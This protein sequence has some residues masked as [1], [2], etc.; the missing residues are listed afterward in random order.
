MKKIWLGLLLIANGALA[1]TDDSILI[2]KISDE[3]LVRGKA[4]ENLRVL[5]KTVGAR[6]S[7][8]QQMYQAEEWGV[9]ALKQAGATK[10]YL[11]ECMVPY[12]IRGGKDI[13]W[14][15]YKDAAGKPVKESLDVLA[16]GNSLGSGKN[17]VK[18]SVILINNFDELEKR[19]DELKGKIVFYNYP[20]NPSYVQTF[21]AYG[22]S[23]IYRRTGPS[24]A[25]K[26]GAVAV[27]IRSMSGSTDNN[28]HTGAT[29]YDTTLPKI[30]CAA[31]GLKDADK[32]SKLLESGKQIEL[33]YQS[34]ARFSPIQKGIM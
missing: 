28:P 33:Y 29:L 11:Q 6:L 30:P 31:M 3:I 24:R 23:G 19:K 15:N 2:K 17:G 12:W 20:F 5:C 27:V 25:A 16:L 8:S 13:A 7:G 21:K 9:A 14:I 32:L 4:Y 10:V 18:A 1:Q 34:N 26:Y 22:E